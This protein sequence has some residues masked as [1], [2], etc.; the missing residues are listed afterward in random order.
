MANINT[1]SRVVYLSV[2]LPI[3]SLVDQLASMPDVDLIWLV[4]QIDQRVQDV[5]FTRELADYFTK[6]VKEL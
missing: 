5:Q 3:D 1:A 2:D 4:K 6:E